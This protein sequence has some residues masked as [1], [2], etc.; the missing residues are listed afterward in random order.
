[1]KNPLIGLAALLALCLTGCSA[2][3]YAGSASLRSGPAAQT[4]CTHSYG[5]QVQV[6]DGADSGLREHRR[7]VTAPDDDDGY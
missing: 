3:V 6:P 4:I 2:G 5:A 1:M 7:C